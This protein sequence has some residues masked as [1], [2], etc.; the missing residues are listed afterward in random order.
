MEKPALDESAS[1]RQ[2]LVRQY[3]WRWGVTEEQA[4]EALARLGSHRLP[5]AR[6]SAAREQRVPAPY[7]D[8]PLTPPEKDIV[9]R[10]A[11]GYT[12]DEVA[13]EI[14]KARNTIKTQL[15][16]LMKKTG[17]RSQA[18]LVAWCFRSGLID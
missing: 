11:R 13:A 10:L 15:A 4:A 18:H 3:A 17:T 7:G 8:V 9:V 1:P 12:V 6:A 5:T 14:Y 16:A 2:D